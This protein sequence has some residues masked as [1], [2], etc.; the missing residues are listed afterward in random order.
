VT[1]PVLTRFDAVATARGDAPAVVGAGRTVSYRQVRADVLAWRAELAGLP[2]GAVVAVRS[3]GS[4][5]LPAAFLGVRAAGLVPLLVD[6]LLPRQRA[7][8]FVTAARPAATLDPERG[9]VTPA[10]A[11]EPVRLPAEAGYLVF[12]S[13]TQGPPKGI[14]GNAAGLLHFLSWERRTLGLGPATRIAM[15]TSP[16]FDVVLRELLLALLVGGRL[17]VPG[18][19][20]RTDPAQVLPWL[21]D[22]AADTVHVVPSLGMRWAAAA[23]GQRLPDLRWTLFAGEPLHARQVLRWREAAPAAA[24]INLYGPS[25]TTLAKF[26]YRVGSRPRPG[27]QPVG[28]PLPGTVLHARRLDG[29]ADG[30][31]IEI[32]TPHGSLGYLPGTVPPEDDRFLV[33]RDGRTRFVTQDRGVLLPGALLRVEGRLDTLVK[34]RGMLVDTGRVEALALDDPLVGAACCVQVNPDTTGEVV[35]AVTGPPGP[36]ALSRRL[37]AVLGTGM[38]DAVLVLPALPQLPNGKVDRGRLRADLRRSWPG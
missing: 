8:A 34:R 17:E 5:D 18:P 25:E 1:C 20:V 4:V 3:A 11:G 35:L 13:G 37:R 23:P 10:T 16:S 38:P 6:T 30:F 22:T 24:A 7:D 32:E 27:L 29:A 15:L 21:A 28:R 9:S 26:W 31:R 33:R 36:A 19:A 2:A 12:S 14:V